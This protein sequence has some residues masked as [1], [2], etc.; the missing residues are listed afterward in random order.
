[1]P[2]GYN[3]L[4]GN[5]PVTVQSMLL[6]RI[7]LIALSTAL[8]LAACAENPSLRVPDPGEEGADED[9]AHKEDTLAL[10]PFPADDRLLRFDIGGASRHE[11]FVDPESISIGADWVIRYTSVVV[12]QSGARTISYEGLD[13][14]DYAYK[15]YA[16]GRPDGT[17]SEVK[18]PEWRP[19]AFTE[20]NRYR[21][22]LFKDFFCPKKVPVRSPGEAVRALR[23]GG[24]S[25]AEDSY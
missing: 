13:C 25:R 9:R 12:S 10:P 3:P 1:V 8:A 6:T 17:W 5:P 19:I 2:L 14:S 24:H 16:T 22:V 7:R 18:R 20:I 4:Q 11:Y 15:L 23:S 21:I